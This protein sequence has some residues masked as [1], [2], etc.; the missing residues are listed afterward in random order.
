MYNS[1][2]DFMNKVKHKDPNETEFHQAVHEVVE[3]LW[4][5]LTSNREYLHHVS[6][7]QSGT[8]YVLSFWFN[9]LVPT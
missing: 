9:A 4:D 8:R 6:R 1:I 5:F 2:E 7:V 3:S